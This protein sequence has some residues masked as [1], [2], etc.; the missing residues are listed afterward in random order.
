MSYIIKTLDF[1]N[2]LDYNKRLSLTNIA[3]IALV[4]KLVVSPSP[5]L[6]TVGSVVIAFSNYM[7]KRSTNQGSQDDQG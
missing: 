6:A 5:D 7:H 1:C 2:I 4:V 3:L